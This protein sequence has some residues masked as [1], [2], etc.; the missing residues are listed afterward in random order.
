MAKKAMFGEIGN[1]SDR[2]MF[3]SHRYG[4]LY[5]DGKDHGIEFFAFVHT[6]AYDSTVFTPN[7]RGGQRREYLDGLHA[8]A[9]YIRDDGVNTEDHIVLLSTCSSSSTNGRDILLARITDE[10]YTDPFI[11]TTISDRKPKTDQDNQN[12][13]VK[14]IPVLTLTLALILAV[15]IIIFIAVACYRRVQDKKAQKRR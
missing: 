9:M 13:F 3:D 4:N 7:V 15:R 8:K 12:G 5:F 2:K 10:V 11:N 14:E 1:F 6:D